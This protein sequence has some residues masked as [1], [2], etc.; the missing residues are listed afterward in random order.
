MKKYVLIG[1]SVGICV[2]LVVV[3]LWGAINGWRNGINIF[4]F[5]H[6]SPGLDGAFL[7]A[8]LALWFYGLPGGLFFGLAGGILGLLVSCSKR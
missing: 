4:H 8:E 2:G 1:M 7:G 6:A 5:A 3:T